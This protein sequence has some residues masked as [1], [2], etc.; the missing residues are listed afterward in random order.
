MD[1]YKRCHE[2]QMG[3]SRSMIKEIDQAIGDFK[4]SLGPI[5]SSRGIVVPLTFSSYS[6]TTIFKDTK[7]RST[8][9][10][11]DILQSFSIFDD[12][13]SEENLRHL[14]KTISTI[15]N[16][17]DPDEEKEEMESNR[18]LQFCLE[19]DYNK[20]KRELDAIQHEYNLKQENLLGS[21]FKYEEDLLK[22]E[23]FMSE[24]P[25]KTSQKPSKSK[26]TRPP[27]S[28]TKNASTSRVSTAR[29]RLRSN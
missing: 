28:S 12:E 5:T 27:S 16:N 2:F 21:K 26:V 24:Q 20:F 19:Q 10:I 8:T 14:L 3:Y 6:N 1:F 9:P 13:S 11:L 22:L 18:K 7:A 17:F 29:S 23:M 4:K 15:Y 25:Q